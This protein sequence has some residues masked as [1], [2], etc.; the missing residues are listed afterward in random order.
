LH[1]WLQH[2]VKTGGQALEYMDNRK[3]AQE[4]KRKQFGSYNSR[5]SIEKG[6]DWTENKPK[7]NS[8][9]SSEELKKF[10]ENFEN[11]NGMK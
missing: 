2:G 5:K 10:F 9:V 4:Q 11:K 1:D 3:K 7:I 6:T 8:E